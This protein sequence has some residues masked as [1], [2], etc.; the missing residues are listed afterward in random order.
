MPHI[1]LARAHSC[2]L[3]KNP[4]VHDDK[5]DADAAVV[6]TSSSGTLTPPASAAPSDNVA[7]R[8]SGADRSDPPDAAVSTPPPAFLPHSSPF[9][10]KVVGLL[11]PRFLNAVPPGASGNCCNGIMFVW[12][13]LSTL[14][15]FKEIF[16]VE[17]AFMS[18]VFSRY[19]RVTCAGDAGLVTTDDAAGGGFIALA[20]ICLIAALM[21]AS[22]CVIEFDAR[23]TAFYCYL[24][25]N[26]LIDFDNVLEHS[27]PTDELSLEC[28]CRAL[29]A[30]CGLT[31][32]PSLRR[33]LKRTWQFWVLVA[34]T[35][36][37]FYCGVDG[38]NL[39]SSHNFTGLTILIGLLGFMW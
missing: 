38:T 27:Q 11:P 21:W 16:A 1:A 24:S 15:T 37:M 7:L 17:L 3:V 36:V 10:K 28:A 2:L 32:L 34:F 31:W 18:W 23:T 22:Q 12:W 33:F 25:R 39:N 6:V 29:R 30:V 13:F 9:D 20:S 19:T 5:K 4:A 8:V 26:V 35:C 14:F